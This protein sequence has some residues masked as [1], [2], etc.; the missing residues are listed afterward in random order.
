MALLVPCFILCSPTVLPVSPGVARHPAVRS[1]PYVTPAA[2][3]L[4]GLSQIPN[5]VGVLRYFR[6][7]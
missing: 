3:R 4:C 5:P 1:R 7:A 6:T 2:H